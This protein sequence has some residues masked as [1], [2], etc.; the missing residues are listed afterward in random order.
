MI[1]PKDWI[2]I[3]NQNVETEVDLTETKE[4]VFKTTQVISSYL[5][6]IAAGPYECVEAKEDQLYK[7]IPMAAY[8]RKSLA[9]LMKEQANEFFYITA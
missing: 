9:K 6:E 5:V 8:C 4:V 3:S 1:I 2:G 7:G